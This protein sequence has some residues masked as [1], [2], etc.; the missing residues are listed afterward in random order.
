MTLADVYATLQAEDMIQI[1]DLPVRETPSKSKSKGRSRGRPPLARRQASPDENADKV[2]LPTSYTIA[3]DRDYVEAVLRNYQSRGYLTLK[4]EKLKY[5]PFLTTRDAEKPPAVQAHAAL[6]AS[7][8]QRAHAD[9][10]RLDEP[11]TPTTENRND[12]NDD[13]VKGEDPETLALVATLSASPKRNLRK[14][15]TAPEDNDGMPGTPQ[16]RKRPRRDFNATPTD[17]TRRSTR[18]AAPISDEALDL[19]PRRSRRGPPPSTS[20]QAHRTPQ[21][22]RAGDTASAAHGSQ[23]HRPVRQSSAG[24]QEDAEMVDADDGTG[25]ADASGEDDDEWGEEDAEGEDDE[26]YV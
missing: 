2:E 22:G 13:V 25:S 9:E 26:E 6:I 23:G 16:Q 17:G 1:H 14:R 4:P 8:A 7:M 18:G 21:Q 20:P 3:F 19:T 11:A 5:H 10:T 12:N 24:G 15:S